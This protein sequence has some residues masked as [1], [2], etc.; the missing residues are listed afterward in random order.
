MQF[1][2][3][4]FFLANCKQNHKKVKI[5]RA[6]TFLYGKGVLFL[7]F[8]LTKCR[9][10]GAENPCE[11][12]EMNEY[13]MVLWINIRFCASDRKFL[14]SQN[15]IVCFFYVFLQHVT[16]FFRFLWK[17]SRREMK[18]KTRNGMVLLRLILGHAITLPLFRSLRNRRLK[19]WL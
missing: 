10:D 1:A 3:L 4:A 19:P 7:T 15:L 2:K 5:I 13:A 18:R 11:T 12:H 16:D 14:I 9:C 17:G 8:R 6:L